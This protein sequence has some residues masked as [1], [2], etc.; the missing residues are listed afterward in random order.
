MSKTFKVSDEMK[1]EMKE[2]SGFVKLVNEIKAESGYQCFKNI[3][4]IK[5]SFSIYNYNYFLFKKNIQLY[6]AAYDDFQLNIADISNLILSSQAYIQ[7]VIKLKRTDSL[8]FTLPDTDPLHLFF[9]S[10]RDFLT[11]TQHYPLISVRSHFRDSEG[12]PVSLSFQSMSKNEFLEYLNSGVSRKQKAGT[13]PFLTII[14][15]INNFPDRINVT[16]LINSYNEKLQR[17]HSEFILSYVNSHLSS[18]NVL[19]CKSEELQNFE[20]KL[21]I[22]P[23]LHDVQVRFLKYLLFKCA[24]T[25]G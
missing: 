18:L 23:P 7:H 9:W 10:L 22:H 11:H 15:F 3:L 17:L 8:S 1:K 21:K 6:E 25:H 5:T 20:S 24:L 16:Q 2:F 12:S 19:I 14:D 4:K 13:N